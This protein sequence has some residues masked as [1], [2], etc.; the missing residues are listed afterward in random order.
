MD[1]FDIRFDEVVTD[2]ADKALRA[3]VSE[4]LRRELRPMF[5]AGLGLIDMEIAEEINASV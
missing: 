4:E 3:A 5:Q 1:E 2:N